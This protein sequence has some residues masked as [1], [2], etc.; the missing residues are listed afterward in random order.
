MLKTTRFIAG[1]LILGSALL[2]FFVSKNWLFFTMFVGLNMI[3]YSF[4]DWCLMDE[5]M[6]KMGAT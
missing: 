5:V 2:G 4:T 1:F 6:K 3:Q